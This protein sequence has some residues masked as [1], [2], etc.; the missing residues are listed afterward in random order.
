MCPFTSA[1]VATPKGDLNFDGNRRAYTVYNT[2]SKISTGTTASTLITQELPGGDWE[3]WPAYGRAG[4]AHFYMECANRGLCDRETGLC[5]CFPGYE[6]YACNRMA[7]PNDCSGKGVCQ[8]TGYLTTNANSVTDAW[9]NVAQSTATYGLWDANMAM[10]CKCDPGYS[11]PDCSTRSCPVGDDILTQVDQVSETQYIDIKTTC[12]GSVDCSTG[13]PLTATTVLSGSIRLTYTDQF[14]EEYTTEPIEGVGAYG[15]SQTLATNAAAALRGLPNNV[16][17]DT[18][19]VKATYCDVYQAQRYDIGTDATGGP[20]STNFRIVAKSDGTASDSGNTVFASDGKIKVLD[21]GTSAIG[22]AM[23]TGYVKEAAATTTAETG[24]FVST[25]ADPLC[26]RLV[27]D[28]NGMSGDIA[29]LKVDVTDVKYAGAT[30]AQLSTAAVS[31]TVS[32]SIVVATGGK[33]SYVAPSTMSIESAAYTGSVVNEAS[34]GHSV[35]TGECTV[36][37]VDTGVL[38]ATPTNT[39]F[40]KTK[41][42]VTCKIASGTTRSLGVHTV[43]AV[44]ATGDSTNGKIYLEGVIPASTISASGCTTAK[45]L[46]E[47]RSHFAV[48]GGDTDTGDI[49]VLGTG[50]DMQ[51][52]MNNYATSLATHKMHLTAGFSAVGGSLNGDTITID[53]AS[54]FEAAHAVKADDTAAADTATTIVIFESESMVTAG[55][56]SAASSVGTILS[57]NVATT[58]A[59]LITGA[60]AFTTTEQG[61]VTWTINGKGTTEVAE[62]GA[63]GLCDTEAGQCKCFPGYIGLSCSTQASIAM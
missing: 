55:K 29:D 27:V 35:K 50:V 47:G 6:G 22:T 21:P 16:V 7:C 19:N 51:N 30:N 42:E 3:S 39:F 31:G 60:E 38:G 61:G 8:S 37:F 43:Y 26:V 1:W 17:P 20:A 54:A 58:A 52:V 63:R 18:V 57:S 46:V 13:T 10:A 2:D 41:I 53:H 14:G 33:Y 40:P 48:T 4:E 24:V 23:D 15:G 5:E 36:V 56:N 62:C 34:C 45:I 11:G 59:A 32:E 12:E 49:A 9:Y 25:I 44:D 28:F